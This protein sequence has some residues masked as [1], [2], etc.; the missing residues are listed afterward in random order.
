MVSVITGNTR[1]ELDWIMDLVDQRHTE[2]LVETAGEIDQRLNHL[3]RVGA[4]IGA[5]EGHQPREVVAR[6]Y[7]NSNAHAV[8]PA[9]AIP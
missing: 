5:F 2:R 3:R 4:L 8:L 1:I 7:A 6:R 9:P